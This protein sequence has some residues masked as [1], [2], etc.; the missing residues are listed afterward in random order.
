MISRTSLK[1]VLASVVF[2]AGLFSLR[3]QA[4]A[5]RVH[6]GFDSEI[7]MSGYQD[8]DSA[9]AEIESIVA[10][11]AVESVEIAS[12]SSPEGNFAYNLDLS[13]RRARYVRK[14]LLWK[15]PQ[16]RGKVS[17]APSAECWDDLKASVSSDDRLSDRSRNAMLSVIDSDLDPDLKEARLK[18]LPGYKA[19]YSNWFRT[20]RYAEI[21]FTL[22]GGSSGS[23]DPY[24][25]S[26][27]APGSSPGG[28]A[29]GVSSGSSIISGA[30]SAPGSSVSDGGLCFPYRGASLDAGF[31]SN[32][33]LLDSLRALLS[34]RQGAE[35]AEILI[36]SSSSIDGPERANRKISAQRAEAVRRW[37]VS[38]YPEL[39][40][41]IRVESRGE[42][43]SRLRSALADSLRVSAS[44][45]TRALEIVDSSLPSDE[46]ESRLRALPEWQEMFENIFPE[47]RRASVFVTFDSVT[48]EPVCEPD[49]AR[50]EEP[51]VPELPIVAVEV[52]EVS[53]TLRVHD[54]LVVVDDLMVV[55]S[56]RKEVRDSMRV[57]DS[58]LRADTLAAPVKPAPVPPVF[59]PL[60]AV[61]TNALLD[62]AITPNFAVE[63]PIGNKWSVFAE[64]T[65]P[66]WVN[67]KN[68]QAWQ[69]LKWDIGARR[70]LSPHNAA[71]KFDILT[72]HFIGIDFGA[73]YYDVEP[74]HTGYQG[75]FQTLGLEYGYA[76]DLGRGWRL[77]A[78]AGA[79]WMGSHYRYYKGDS[80]DEHLIYQYNG[81]LNWFGPI[82]VGVSF[83]Y[84]I[85]VKDRRN[86][87]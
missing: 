27:S 76:W 29:S 69:M 24:G 30:G 23:P 61:S 31:G 18:A 42:D 74:R 84:I 13:H 58:D 44:S 53:D 57:E 65:F 6:F 43:W 15:Y 5:V 16:L 40:R 1:A 32:R 85:P 21:R 4:P 25:S 19:F 66:W 35:I 81:K 26:S 17:V 10:S 51:Q 56:L 82:K 72:G 62:L 87:R 49:P 46:K 68:D 79:G 77:D 83:K 50:V 2:L 47:S 20:Y 39:A 8:N 12:F 54:E 78:Y 67:R 73:G 45:R 7:L 64:Y 80:K 63:V 33:A 34:S 28:S 38:E 71:D 36:V 3:A 55:D 70:W 48:C 37:I 60:L 22:K 9:L 41:K 11:G 52:E 75:E 86:A 14:Y 59:K